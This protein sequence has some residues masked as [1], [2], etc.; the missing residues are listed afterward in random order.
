M[1]NLGSYCYLRIIYKLA[2]MFILTRYIKIIVELY[3]IKQ[4]TTINCKINI[5]NIHLLVYL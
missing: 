3:L 5:Q 1:C 4:L 2:I